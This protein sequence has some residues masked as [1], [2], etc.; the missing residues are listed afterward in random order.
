MKTSVVIMAAGIGSR[1]GGGIKQL[2]PVGPH[3]EIIMDYSIHDAIEAGFNKIIFIIRK[4]IEK[5]FKEVIGDRISEAAKKF[6]IEIAYAYQALDDLPEGV[7]LPADRKKPW[8][9]GQAVLC[10]KELIQEPFV[11]INADDYYGKEAFV[12]IHDF[13][14]RYNQEKPND[15]CMA[16][17][18][19]KNTLSDNGVVT[20]GVCQVDDKGYLSM[21]K[22][23]SNIAKT[24]DG[25]E[26]D[27]VKL[28]INSHVSM[29]M[30]GLTPEFVGLLEEGFISFF[31]NNPDML[32]GEYLLPI[33]IGDLLADNRVTVQVLET[34][35]TWFG[36]TYK[37]DAPVV[38][39]AFKNLIEQG[40]YQE[41]LMSDL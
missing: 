7:K 1:F 27:G 19:L 24:K 12:T 5:D 41:D 14:L 30:W 11:V 22:E 23:T 39:E 34:K 40:V 2:E 29:N 31:K 10:A 38:K 15:L 20:R 32:K 17:F 4:D 6:N 8:G 13:L 37:E 3:G 26:A 35:D 18:I 28:D 33:L 36:V 16:G 9:T 25:A 21:I